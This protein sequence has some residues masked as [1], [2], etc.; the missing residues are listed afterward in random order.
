MNPPSWMC[1]VVCTRRSSAHNNN[2]NNNPLRMWTG[3]VRHVCLCV[4]VCAVCFVLCSSFYNVV[5]RMHTIFVVFSFFFAVCLCLCLCMC[6]CVCHI[7]LNPQV[8]EKDYLQCNIW[9]KKKYI[10]R[11]KTTPKKSNFREDKILFSVRSNWTPNTHTNT[12]THNAVEMKNGNRIRWHVHFI[13]CR[14]Q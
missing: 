3:S 13:H 14:R 8:D 1:V 5:C 7:D 2:N 12:Q 11:N 4:C 9:G 10:M 6:A